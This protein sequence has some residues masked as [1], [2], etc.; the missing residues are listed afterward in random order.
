[1]VELQRD[2]K[3]MLLVKIPTLIFGKITK[4]LHLPESSNSG[5]RYYSPISS[6]MQ[7]RTWRECQEACVRSLDNWGGGGGEI[8]KLP[9]RGGRWGW[10]WD[11]SKAGVKV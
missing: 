4:A 2:R 5:S 9:S 8:G 11:V 3:G 1:M 10:C 6:Q 7:T